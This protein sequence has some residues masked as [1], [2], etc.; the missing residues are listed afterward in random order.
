MVVPAKMVVC[1]SIAP[2][3]TSEIASHGTPAGRICPNV[4]V[5]GSSN[6]TFNRA[7][8]DL[9]LCSNRNAN[10][11]GTTSQNLDLF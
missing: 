5:S 9:N 10:F 4:A 6:R 8:C 11:L 1:N 2:N 7:I 3:H